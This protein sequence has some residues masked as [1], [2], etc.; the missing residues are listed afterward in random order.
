M[1]CAELSGGHYIL[2]G[3][4]DAL[5]LYF[6]TTTIEYWTRT[7]QSDC[8]GVCISDSVVCCE[9]YCLWHTL[10]ISIYSSVG[11]FSV[12]FPVRLW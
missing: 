4:T 10:R 12:C 7:L 2:E 6:E 5:F 8:H 1:S 9:A 11:V 3:V